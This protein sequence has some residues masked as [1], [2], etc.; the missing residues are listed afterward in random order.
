MRYIKEFENIK[1]TVKKGDYVI[2]Y[3]K[4]FFISKF[5]LSDYIG[6]VKSVND[7]SCI[8]EYDND[9]ID[10]TEYSSSTRDIKYCSNNR[11]DLE[12]ILNTNKFNI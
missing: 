9:E 5:N 2:C 3:G 8:V 10:I 11:E 6:R 4:Y 7:F 1:N 12:N